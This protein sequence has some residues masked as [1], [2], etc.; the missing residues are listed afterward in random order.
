MKD[1]KWHQEFLASCTMMNSKL[2]VE[3]FLMIL[4]LRP[5]SPEGV[6]ELEEEFS[7]KIA[8]AHARRLGLKV[9]VDILWFLATVAETPGQVVMWVHFIA[10]LKRTFLQ[11]SQSTV[12]VQLHQLYEYAIHRGIPSKESMDRLWNLQKIDGL[13]GLDAMT[14]ADYVAG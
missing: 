1:F 6:A 14:E 9:D 2:Q 11:Q 13:N 4:A 10:W 8:K 3:I 12:P 5:F 7:V